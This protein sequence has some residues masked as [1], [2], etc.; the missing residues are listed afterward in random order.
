[1]DRDHFP[2]DLLKD[3]SAWYLIYDQL[4]TDPAGTRTAARRRRLLELSRRVTGHPFWKTSAGTPAARM[5]LK[6]IARAQTGA[7]S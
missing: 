2:S 7:G 5:A 3:Q 4:A 1:M 6:K